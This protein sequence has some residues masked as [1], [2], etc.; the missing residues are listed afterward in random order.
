MAKKFLH[1]VNIQ[2]RLIAADGVQQFDLAVNPLSVLLLTIRPL[3]DTGTLA[4][5]ES[6]LGICGALDRITVLLNGVSVMSMTGRDAAALAF[7]RHGIV[8][9]QANHV[10]TNNDRRAVVLPILFGSEVYSQK[11]CFPA[12]KRGELILEVD[13][14]IAATGYDGVRFS[15]ETIELPGAKPKEYERKVQNAVTFTAT[16]L[17]DVELPIGNLVRGILCFGTTGFGGAAPSPTLGRMATYVN[18]E[19]MGYT[20]HDFEVAHMMSSLQGGG[21]PMFDERVTGTTVDGNAG[22]SVPSDGTNSSIGSGGWGN[23]AF[24]N[25]DPTGD[26]EYS[27]DTRGSSRFH[28]EVNAETANL[29]RFVTIERIKV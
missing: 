9:M 15:V 28:L 25:F 7:F 26:D 21:P 5:F 8:P 12:T 14:D 10:I 24:L 19:Q 20:S 18:N 1:S 6:Y 4:N 16:G 11:S 2:E 23:Y 17:N 29:A 22:T 27:F 3:N 13:F